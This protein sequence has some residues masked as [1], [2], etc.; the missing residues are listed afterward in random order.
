M[1]LPPRPRDPIECLRD[2]IDLVVMQAVRKRQDLG[3]QIV[4]PR[5]LLRQMHGAAFDLGSLR[6]HP[7]DLIA[8]RPNCHRRFILIVEVLNEART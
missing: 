1:Q 3:S 7:E 6:A 2:R 4:Q 8:L 5:A